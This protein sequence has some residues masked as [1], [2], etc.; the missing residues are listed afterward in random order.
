MQ[1]PGISDSTDYGHAAIT[2]SSLAMASF[3]IPLTESLSAGFTIGF[4]K[5]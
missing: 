4:M 3:G 2:T 1:I 5:G